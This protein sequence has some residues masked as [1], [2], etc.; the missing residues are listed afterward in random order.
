MN[1]NKDLDSHMLMNGDWSKAYIALNRQPESR[2]DL[3]RRRYRWINFFM[4][5]S[6]MK[7]FLVR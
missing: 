2:V 3:L 7:K 4:P 1:K 5:K 6:W